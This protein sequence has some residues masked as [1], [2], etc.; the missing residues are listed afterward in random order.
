MKR[1]LFIVF[2]LQIYV[3]SA[4]SQNINYIS[5]VLNYYLQMGDMIYDDGGLM[6]TGDIVDST[7]LWGYFIGRLDSNGEM[8]C[9]QHY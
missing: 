9:F 2:F 1:L 7:L 8:S 6:M 3:E 4:R 5:S